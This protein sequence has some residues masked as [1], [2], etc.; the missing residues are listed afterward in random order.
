MKK[1]GFIYDD[2]YLKHDWPEHPENKNRL[3]SILEH[4]EK[5]GIKKALIDVKPRRAKVE[6]VALNH[7]PA[8]IQEIHDFCK[9]GGGYLDPDTYATPDTYDVALYAVGGVL[10]GIDRIL[11]GELDRA[12]CAVRPPGHH[13]EY[14]KAMGFC[15]FNNVAIGAHYLRK[16]KGVNKVFIIDFDAHHGN[17]TQK[18]FYEDDTV[19]YFSTHE[20]P[21][22]PGTGS[23]DERGAGK[24]YGYTY[25]VPM[26]AGAG[27][28]EYIPVYEKL[29]PELMNRFS[30]DFVLVSAG[31]DLHR[32]DPLTYLNVSNEGV[33]QIVRN[34]IKTSDELNAPVL[35]ALEGGYNLK[36][37]GE[38]VVI[39]L[40][41]MLR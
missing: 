5:S 41:E 14:A 32:D 34:I 38:C 36:A 39:T 31:Y 23:E 21:F 4:V 1:V 8:Y 7:D 6:E 22:Y 18:S 27:D 2:I 13:A 29:L 28:D 16:I 12:F 10:E 30:P 17:G 3:I 24:G 40:E 15:I 9:S 26:S 11:S 35:F 37:L 25:N 20:Y 19:F 33:R